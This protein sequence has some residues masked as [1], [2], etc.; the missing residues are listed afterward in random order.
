MQ[1]VV[2]ELHQHIVA[3]R[4]L[5]HRLVLVVGPPGS[6][7]TRALQEASTATFAPLLNVNLELSLRMLELS[8]TQRVLQ[9]SRLLSDIVAQTDS[10]VVLLDNIEILFDVRLEQDSLRLIKGLSRYRTILAAWDGA[11]VDGHLVHATPDHR[12]YRRYPVD[13]FLVVDMNTKE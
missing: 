13:G 7:K 3:A 8:E 4:E 6:G 10:D 12:E 1:G 9:A 11:V 5:Y 2:A